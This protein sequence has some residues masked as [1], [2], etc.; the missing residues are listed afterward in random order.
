MRRLFFSL[1]LS[2]S[3]ACPKPGPNPNPPPSTQTTEQSPTS[4]TQPTSEPIAKAPV[5]FEPVKPVAP[6]ESKIVSVEKAKEGAF[7][8]Q[9]ATLDNGLT[10]LTLEDHSSPVAAV[11]LWFHVGSKD[12]VKDRRGFAHMFEHMMFRGTQRL[13]PKDHLDYVK[14]TGGDAN[15]YT[16]FDQTVYIQEIP[17]N[18]LEMIFWLESE[19]MAFLRI[20]E[21]GFKTERNVVAE[22]FRVGMEAPYGDVIDKLLAQLFPNHPYGW[23]PIGNMDELKAST[24]AELQHFWETYYIPNN[25][26]LVVTGD[27]KHAEVQELARK[28]F[29]WIPRYPEPPRPKMESLPE[30]T[31][32]ISLKAKNGP[33][34]IL[35]YVFRTVPA[36]HKDAIALELLGAIFGGGES[37]RLYRSLVIEKKSAMFALAAPISL[38]G[39]GLFGMGAILSPIGGDLAAAKK[40]LDAQL[41]KLQTEGVTEKELTK[42]KNQALRSAIEGRGTA[43]NKAD[44][45]GNALV[46]EHD[47]EG[48]NQRLEEIKAITLDDLKRVTNTYL[49]TDK[50]IPI[51]VAPNLLG[52]LLGAAGGSSAATPPAESAPPASGPTGKP[53]LTRPSWMAEKPPLGAPLKE[54]KFPKVKE[55]ALKNGLKVVFLEDHELPTVSVSL[56]VPY[57]SISDPKDTPGIASMAASLLTHGTKSY[58]YLTLTEELDTYAISLGGSVSLDQSM[59]FASAI[60]EE[61]PRMMK[62]LAEAVLSPTFPKDQL[63]LVRGQAKTGKAIQEKEP[64]FLADREFRKRLYGEHPYARTPEGESSDLDKITPEAMKA[65]WSTYVRPDTSVLYIAGD[66]TEAQA[67]ALAKENFGAWK[68]T[69]A[70]PTLSLPAFPEAGPTKIYLVDRA[71]EQAQIRVGYRAFGFEHPRYVEAKVLNQVFG[72]GFGSRLNELIRVKLGL[73]YGAGGGFRSQRYAGALQIGTFSKNA[74]VG[75]TVSAIL[76]E[77]KRLSTEPPTEEEVSLAKTYLSG[78]YVLQREDPKVLLEDHWLVTYAKLPKDFYAQYLARVDQ[79]TPAVMVE[80]IKDIVRSDRLTIVVVGDAKTL[81]PQL[82]KIATVELVK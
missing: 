74:T 57:G 35:G 2:L 21:A 33:A 72:G 9:K 76:D 52:T 10:I 5:V 44:R 58:D 55:S 62:L 34:P 54:A 82:E 67:L 4:Q 13:G 64:N 27:I 40:E 51:Q 70:A 66:L 41:Y 63:D 17:A 37:S 81:T 59:V 42:A 69:G 32:A 49:A 3:L 36:G 43:A 14:K 46:I 25:A 47:L 20:D 80:T 12:E 77:L 60:K 79:A 65:W 6:G 28:Y 16:N 56:G 38:E 61:A 50:A 24:S 75:A 30:K 18:Q 8:Y 73:T 26:T 68:A 39:E 53:G 22:E 1:L 7:A 19:R 15:A 45:L 71:G 11:Q 31:A 29:G 23:S 78:S 48:V